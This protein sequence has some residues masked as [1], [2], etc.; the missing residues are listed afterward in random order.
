MTDTLPPTGDNGQQT[1]PQTAWYGEVDTDTKGYLENKGWKSPIEAITS[2]RNLERA[3]GAEKA[4]RTVVLPGDKA[5]PAELDAFFNKLGRPES[6]EKY[7]LK[8]PDGADENTVKWF[9]ETAHKHGL[10]AKQAAALFDDYNAMTGTLTQAQM[11]AQKAQI[12]QEVDGLKKEWGAAFDTK[13]SAAKQAVKAFGIE[14]DTI[15]AIEQVMGF[16]RVMKF[17]DQI[18]AKVAEPGFASQ[19]QKTQS[20]GALTPQAAMDR[21][22]EKKA[23]K[24]FT[25][26]LVAGDR[27]AQAEWDRL[28]EMAY[29]QR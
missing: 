11:E 18:G 22:A 3:F 28:H 5:E 17:F 15:D 12:A 23:D 13:V 21:I 25:A 14:P 6:P 1:P 8:A 19:E 2:Y 10:S 4:G 29:G 24:T 7:E 26:R 16:S 27:S 20:F 9:K